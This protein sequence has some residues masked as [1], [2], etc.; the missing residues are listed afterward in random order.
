MVFTCT[1]IILTRMYFLS[2]K[3]VMQ[4]KYPSALLFYIMKKNT[5]AFKRF[6]VYK[7]LKCVP[8]KH[9]TSA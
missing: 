1:L 5:I 4:R 2:I 7:S 3:S 6:F 9:Q 8:T